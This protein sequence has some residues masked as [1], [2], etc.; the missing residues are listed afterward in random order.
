MTVSR[1]LWLAKCRLMRRRETRKRRLR[2]L[3]TRRKKQRHKRLLLKRKAKRR[4]S[5]RMKMERRKKKIKRMKRRSNLKRK[6]MSRGCMW[7]TCHSKLKL[8]KSEHSLRNLGKCRILS[9]QWSITKGQA[10]HSWSLRMLKQPLQPMPLW[11]RLTSKVVSCTSCLHRRNH[12]RYRKITPLTFKVM[13]SRPM[14][15]LMRIWRMAKR[16]A[17]AML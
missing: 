4:G 16:R 14:P 2:T 17:G 13:L 15:L 12:L 5:R 9:Y 10:M 1:T 6:L 8:R 11:T 7:W 3:K